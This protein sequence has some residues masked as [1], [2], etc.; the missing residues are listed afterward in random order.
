LDENLTKLTHQIGI[1]VNNSHCKV[2]LL[3]PSVE[4]NTT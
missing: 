4:T 2:L 3:W 1:Y